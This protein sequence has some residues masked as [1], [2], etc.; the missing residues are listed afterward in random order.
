MRTTKPPSTAP[1]KRPSFAKKALCFGEIHGIEDTAAVKLEIIREWI[2]LG[3]RVAV[4]L[5]RDY[6]QEPLVCRWLSTGTPDEKI[7]SAFKT[8][9]TASFLSDQYYFLQGLADASLAANGKLCAICVDISF[10]PRDEKSRSARI[11]ACRSADEFDRR[12]ELFI[13]SRLKAAAAVLDAADRVMFAAGNMHVSRTDHYFPL[14]EAPCRHIHTAAGWLDSRY[15]CESV[16]TLPFSGYNCY[17]SRDGLKKKAQHPSSPVFRSLV[18]HPFDGFR[19]VVGAGIV[20]TA[21]LKS[22]DWLFGIKACR[23][24]ARMSGR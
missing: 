13:I 23:P 6:D 8:A 1:V 2:K 14:R 3:L 21:F 22:Y 11:L 9:S 18:A 4:A 20:D 16:Y 24:S 12:R 10:L 7:Q 15:G 5:E 19:Q 17:Q